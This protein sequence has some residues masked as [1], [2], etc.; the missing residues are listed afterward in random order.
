MGRTLICSNAFLLTFWE[1]SCRAAMCLGR[2]S[3]NG[4]GAPSA[5]DDAPTASLL[6]ATRFCKC[7]CCPS[8]DFEGG[9]PVLALSWA[10]ILSMSSLLRDIEN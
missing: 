4:C 9:V 1:G 3:A 2:E 7:C 10:Q 6:V 8:L 5:S